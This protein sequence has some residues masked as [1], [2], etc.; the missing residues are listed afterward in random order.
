MR[1][2]KGF[3]MVELVVVIAI[4][5][6]IGGIGVPR[7]MEYFKISRGHRMITD[8]RLL[9]GAIGYYIAENG[10][11]PTSLDDLVPKLVAAVPEKLGADFIVKQNNGKEKEYTGAENWA[12]SIDP[13]TN[14]AIYGGGS[15][16]N[17]EFYL[18]GEGSVAVTGGMAG[19]AQYANSALANYIALNGKNGA[20]IDSVSATEAQLLALAG[21]TGLNLNDATMWQF[22][23]PGGRPVM[24]WTDAD[25]SKN[26]T[27]SKPRSSGG[28]LNYQVVPVIAYSSDDSS[29]ATVSSDGLVRDSSHLQYRV[30]F[31]V[32]NSDGT[33][34]S[35]LNNSDSTSGKN[36]DFTAAGFMNR[37][38]TSYV[39][40][41]YESA[42]AKYNQLLNVYN[43]VD[44]NNSETAIQFNTKY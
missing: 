13:V 24:L 19:I 6:I 35:G 21:D 30:Y 23:N 15:D 42:V 7:M 14:R 29:T 26:V 3:T 43:N 41:S 37:D 2:R 31:A 4:L 25:L 36:G 39:C 1:G 40:D 5:G 33:F 8:L 16:H 18:N 38:G 34:N 12:F 9:D 22:C 27:M 17:L 28:Y 32:V 10:V 20:N 11:P 44:K